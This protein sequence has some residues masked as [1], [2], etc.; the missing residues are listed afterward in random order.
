MQNLYKTKD[1]Y[2]ASYLV[3]HGLNLVQLERTDRRFFF[4]FEEGE[5]LKPLCDEFYNRQAKVE[6]MAYVVAMKQVK[7]KMYNESS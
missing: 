7:S 4:L 2:L 5:K 3:M 6:P 1:L